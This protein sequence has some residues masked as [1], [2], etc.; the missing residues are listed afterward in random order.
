MV[1][2]YAE[3]EV[4]YSECADRVDREFIYRLSHF[5]VCLML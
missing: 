5:G 1:E 3:Q 2:G 4:A